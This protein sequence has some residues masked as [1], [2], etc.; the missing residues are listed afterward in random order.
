MKKDNPKVVEHVAFFD[1]EAAHWEDRYASDPRFARRFARIAE[2]F[3]LVLPAAPG[4]ALDVGCGT[5]IFSRE[6]ARRGWRVTA[7]DASPE[8]I[9]HAQDFRLSHPG[10]RKFRQFVFSKEGRVGGFFWIG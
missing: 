7:L 6:L 8:M 4:R 3:N 1:A 9:E 10:K 2:L 5:G